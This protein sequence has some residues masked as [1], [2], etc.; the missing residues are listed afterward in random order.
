[1]K[2]IEVENTHNQSSHMVLDTNLNS[3][4]SAWRQTVLDWL[5]NKSSASTVTHSTYSL[6]KVYRIV[7]DG[8]VLR[9]QIISKT[10]QTEL[11]GIKKKLGHPIGYTTCAGEKVYIKHLIPHSYLKYLKNLEKFLISVS[12]KTI[13]PAFKKQS[14]R[15]SRHGL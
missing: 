14:I 10:Y 6:P 4:E 8:D 9:L 3:N 12:H 7:S 13:S 5:Q 11:K 15:N 1:M 2:V